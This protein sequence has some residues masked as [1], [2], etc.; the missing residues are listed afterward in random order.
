MFNISNEPRNTELTQ[1]LFRLYTWSLVTQSSNSWRRKKNIVL[2]NNGSLNLHKDYLGRKNVEGPDIVVSL[3]AVMCKQL[4]WMGSTR[5]CRATKTPW[6]S[7][8]AFPEIASLR[9]CFGV[10]LWCVF[11]ER[12]REK[13]SLRLFHEHVWKPHLNAPTQK[14][15]SSNRPKSERWISPYTSKHVCETETTVM[16]VVAT[17]NK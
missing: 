7:F 5:C 13:E 16:C 17:L 2:C 14:K 12:E 4:C 11:R 3:C 9:C 8:R 6:W 15:K 10:Y 1:T